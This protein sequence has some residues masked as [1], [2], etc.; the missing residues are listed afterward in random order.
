MNRLESV[1]KTE[2]EQEVNSKESA[3]EK[4]KLLKLL[5]ICLISCIVLLVLLVLSLV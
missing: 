5:I 4:K 3:V 1:K 2:T